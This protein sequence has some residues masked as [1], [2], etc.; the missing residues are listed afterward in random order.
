MQTSFRHFFAVG[1]RNQ[2]T[3]SFPTIN[4]IDQNPILLLSSNRDADAARQTK[5]RKRTYN[6]AGFEQPFHKL[7]RAG[8]RGKHNH[9]EIRLRG[10]DQKPRSTSAVSTNRSPRAFT[11][12]ERLTKA[13]S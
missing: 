4:G 1:C 7:S 13:S 12:S 6:H 11:S 3:R 9:R 2:Q 5:T 10:N 8:G